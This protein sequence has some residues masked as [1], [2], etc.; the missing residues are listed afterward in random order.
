MRYF[1]AAEE[2]LKCLEEVPQQECKNVFFVYHT[3][4]SF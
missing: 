1:K 3:Y 4:G 2:V